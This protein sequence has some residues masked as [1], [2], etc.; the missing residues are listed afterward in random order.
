[1]D[2][3]PAEL[4]IH[5]LQLAAPP[6]FHPRLY[7]SRQRT[8]R[9]LCLVSKRLRDLAQP[10]LAQ[11]VHVK[12]SET[13]R[14]L[15][16]VENGET[17][18]SRVIVLVVER[19]ELT[20]SFVTHAQAMLTS[21]AAALGVGGLL[22]GPVELPQLLMFCSNL[23]ELS[24]V[25][26]SLFD[27]AWLRPLSHLRRLQVVKHPTNTLAS[28]PVDLVLP[29]LVEL[30]VRGAQPILDAAF[31]ATVVSTTALPSLRALGLS[32]FE[33]MPASFARRQFQSCTLVVQL[34]PDHFDYDQ[35][36]KK[37]L[38]LKRLRFDVRF[39]LGQ[40]SNGWE[41]RTELY[42]APD[43]NTFVAQPLAVFIET[44]TS[45]DINLVLPRS[46][47]LPSPLLSGWPKPT[48]VSEVVDALLETCEELGIEVFWEEFKGTYELE[49]PSCWEALSRARKERVRAV[50]GR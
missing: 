42:T 9:S 2:R 46:L 47:I 8:L 7:R 45:L 22:R 43:W 23:V 14:S 16:V 3:F 12:C 19:Y 27:F 37:L 11:V 4:V 41:I 25:D 39:R 29:S 10:M 13:S 33:P 20:V 1:M 5:I 30:S 48:F 44:L 50:E 17:R 15:G 49:V 36:F 18:A 35:Q 34:F 21:I 24:I 40:P 32:D 38:E 31:F 28:P 26:V 6:E